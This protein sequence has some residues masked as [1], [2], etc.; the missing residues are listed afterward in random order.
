MSSKYHAKSR[1]TLQPLAGQAFEVETVSARNYKVFVGTTEY[2]EEAANILMQAD[3]G[4]WSFNST[5]GLLTCNIQSSLVADHTARLDSFLADGLGFTRLRS[6]IKA[7]QVAVTAPANTAV[8]TVSGTHTSTNVQT[9]AN[10]TWTGS[11]T[12]TYSYQWMRDG[13]AISGANAQTYTLQVADVAHAIKV[14]VK[15]T[16]SFGATTAD[17]ATFTPAS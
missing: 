9:A 6:T 5:T 7:N 3:P 17:S 2:T 13:V 4:Y 16:S 10:G 14:R 1:A 15:A 11:G 8:P 12:L